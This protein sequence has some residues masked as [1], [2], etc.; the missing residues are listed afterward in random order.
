MKYSFTLLLILMLQSFAFADAPPRWREFKVVS[1]NKKFQANVTRNEND[2]LKQ[3]WDSKWILT[4]YKIS[5][6]D[7]IEL[8]KTDYEFDGYTEGILSNDGSI[9]VYVNFW[10]Y[11]TRSIVKIYNQGVYTGQIK[12]IDF[13]VPTDKRI[14]TVSHELWLSNEDQL[15]YFEK[16]GNVFELVI[17]TIDKKKYK[18]DCA[19]GEI[20]K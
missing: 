15:Y 19:K 14:K 5:G 13:N 12:G 11:E 7:S 6:K 10:Y 1:E 17:H 18:I 8:W 16:N 4:V 20:I 3:P 2:S 9:F